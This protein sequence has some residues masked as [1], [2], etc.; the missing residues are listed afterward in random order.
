MNKTTPTKGKVLNFDPSKSNK[1]TGPNGQVKGQHQPAF[2]ENND[3]A[4]RI[5]EEMV[6]RSAAMQKIKY[7]VK[8]TET[9][10]D[11][12]VKDFY[13]SVKW[14]GYECYAIDESY[15][16]ISKEVSKLKPSKTG[17]VSIKLKAEFLEATFHF[18]KK[19]FGT[20]LESARKH[21]LLAEDFSVAMA[22][23]NEDRAELR[24]IA[25]KAE[26]AKHGISVEE[27]KTAAELQAQTAQQQG[28]F[29]PP[30]Q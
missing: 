10:L 7:T 20:G 30:M 9:S 23:L 28:G 12:L 2:D 25:M 15:K 11:Y 1:P 5:E 6:L 13:Q 8:S 17:R 27:Y 3:E 26:A 19:H 24:E 18:I 21:R 22:R 14:E 4:S 16:E 29:T